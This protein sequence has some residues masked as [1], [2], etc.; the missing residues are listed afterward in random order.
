MSQRSRPADC[1]IFHDVDLIPAN[2]NNMYACSTQPRHMSASIDAFDYK[3][4]YE[5]L[6]G[7]AVA[8]SAGQ[9]EAANGYSNEFFGW[10]GE[11]DDFYERVTSFAGL[12]VM[13]FEAEL[14]RYVMLSHAKE[15]PNPNRFQILSRGRYRYAIDGLSDLKFQRA[16]VHL[17]PLYTR[18]DV[19]L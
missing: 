17:M 1:Y 15:V 5:Q 13:R 19:E 7:G 18:I 2:L 4:P 16:Q 8:L 9:F 11:D 12:R 10:G 14:S 6:V 3:L